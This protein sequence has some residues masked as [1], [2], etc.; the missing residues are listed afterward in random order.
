LSAKDGAGDFIIKSNYITVRELNP[1]EIFGA[2]LYDWWDFTDNS[3][4]NLSGSNINS[5]SS[6]KSGSTRSFVASGGARPTLVSNLVNGLQGARF[7]GLASFMQ[8]NS[9]TALYNFLHN[10]TNGGCVIIVSRVTDL[11][12]NVL[13][14]F[15]G[16]NSLNPV[17]RGVSIYYDD[18]ISFPRNN[19]II[20][21]ITNGVSTVAVQLFDN[22]FETQQFNA[23]TQIFDPKNVTA[24]ERLNS[25]VNFGADN[26][27]NID[28][29][30]PTTSNATNNM[31]LGRNNASGSFYLKGDIAEIII[32]QNQPTLAQLTQIQTYLTNKY[33]TFPI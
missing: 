33:G 8:V 22:L 26:K 10:Q 7:D 23:L 19:N 3:T 28:T 25:I 29:E 6:K 1:S 30:V 5:V 16:N 11:N 18:R 27:A 20:S 12:P 4:L 15:L 24:L 21:Q 32:S 2:D 17:N 31:L 14:P 13:M 9:S